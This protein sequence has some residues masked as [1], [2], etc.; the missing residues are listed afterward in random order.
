MVA[1]LGEIRYCKSVVV[2]HTDAS[3]MP[4][5]E[6]DRRDLNLITFATQPQTSK[7]TEKER[8]EEEPSQD[9]CVP[10]SYTMATHVLPPPP[11]PPKSKSDSTDTP[12]RIYQTTNPILSPREDTVLSVATLERAVVTVRGKR[13]VRDFWR[14][15]DDSEEAGYGSEPD[16]PLES[17]NGE[18]WS[19]RWG[20]SATQRGTL[21][22]LQGAG[23]LTRSLRARRSMPAL[24]SAT[25][26]PAGQ[27]EPGIW[28]CGSYAHS[29][30]PLLEGC[31]VSA[32]NVVEQGIWAAE[33]VQEEGEKVRDLW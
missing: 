32:R 17:D 22:P 21:G 33:G 4:A 31:V 24:Q 14:S 5:D 13:A 23:R 6:R 19:V 15:G 29:G 20:C 1:S 30:I 12:I 25:R 2:N 3:L 18:R 27:K 9:L 8:E 11:P 16:S 10:S 28:I 7:T 26:K